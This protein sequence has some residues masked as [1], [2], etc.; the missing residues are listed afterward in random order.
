[1]SGGDGKG[2]SVGRGTT[3]VIVSGGGEV[4][5]GAK[6]SAVTDIYQHNGN[7]SM[8]IYT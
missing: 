6:A 7:Y 4:G 8:K 5:G 2:V 1:M 3:R